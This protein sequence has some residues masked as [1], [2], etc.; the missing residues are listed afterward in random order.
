MLIIKGLFKQI[1]CSNR[2]IETDQYV[3][4]LK[5]PNYDPTCLMHVLNEVYP[6]KFDSSVLDEYVFQTFSLES[7]LCQNCN[8]ASEKTL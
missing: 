7:V 3:Q 8:H 5:L 4:S 6:L 2:P 1:E